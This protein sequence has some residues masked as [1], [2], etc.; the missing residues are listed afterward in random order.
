MSLILLLWEI[1]LGFN[2][3]RKGTFYDGKYSGD[4]SSEQEVQKTV[5]ESGHL[6][7]GK[8]KYSLWAAGAERGGQVDAA[9]GADGHDRS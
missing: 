3:E 7:R 4:G 5:C 9:E 2:D 6:D 1:V 8:E